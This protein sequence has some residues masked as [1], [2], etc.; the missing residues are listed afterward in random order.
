MFLCK[1]RARKQISLHRDNKVVLYC[2]VLVLRLSTPTARPALRHVTH[3]ATFRHNKCP[4]QVDRDRG[5]AEEDKVNQE[6]S[7]RPCS[8]YHPLVYFFQPRPVFFIWWS[9]QPLF[10]T[11]AIQ[12]TNRGQRAI[13]QFWLCTWSMRNRAGISTR[14][15]EHYSQYRPTV[16]GQWKLGQTNSWQ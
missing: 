14:W 13:L 1:W 15:H 9:R 4:S 5:R 3:S 2:I 16:N 7:K 8:R 11:S 10:S 12:T 6:Q